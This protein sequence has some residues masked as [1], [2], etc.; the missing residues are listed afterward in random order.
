[1]PLSAKT[2]INFPP[3]LNQ[4]LLAAILVVALALRLHGIDYGLWYDEISAY[5]TY[6][7]MSFG[8]ILT[9]FDSENNHVLFTL[10]A[11]VSYELFGGHTWAIR[12]P[13][14]LFGVA[15]IWALYLLASRVGSDLEALISS[16]LLTFSYHH[17]WFSQNARGYTGLL[18][19]S[20]FTSWL[21]LQNLEVR[22]TSKWILYAMAA[23]LGVYTHITML[24]VVIGHFIIFM[25]AF[26]FRRK[27]IW[28]ECTTGLFF[29]FCTAAL[30]TL[31]LYSPILPQVFSTIGQ[32]TSVANW[33]SPFWT[34]LELV[35][36]MRVGFASI[37]VVIGALFLTGAGLLSF[38]QTK[39]VI[40]GLLT[41]PALI[42]SIVVVG[43]GHPL[44]PRFFF[45]AVGFGALIIIRGTFV[46]AQV[47]SRPLKSGPKPA[48]VLGTTLSCL[49]IA[50]SALSI[51]RVYGPKQDFEGALAY[52][53]KHRK[54]GDAIITI[55]LTRF[56]YKSLYRMD[57]EEVET[58]ERLDSIRHR[59]NRM[60]LLYTFPSHVQAEYPDIMA[61][62]QRN[63]TLMRR[64]H[65]TLNEGSIY[66]CVSKSS[67]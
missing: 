61:V 54:P 29:G 65:G 53:E 63:F 40:V 33:N 22:S 46:V 60:I 19:W 44:W 32:K 11:R 50:A 23:S 47:I 66:V 13:A 21:L 16:A 48:F 10:L 43:M 59:S 38:V 51:P 2:D 35:R 15:S 14:V 58:K 28:A 18:F 24:F 42:G 5:V 41:I 25:I 45:F 67:I 26:F 30:F 36:G 6:M 4:G 27:T 3:K 20:L 62:I 17:I 52:I 49:L 34:L 55:G 31:L 1:M 9:T 12:I 56:P 39:P 7:Q 57:W 8:K 37:V 64:F